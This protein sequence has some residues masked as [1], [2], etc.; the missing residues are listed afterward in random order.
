MLRRGE[1]R[2]GERGLTYI[3]QGGAILGSDVGCLRDDA[4]LN[5]GC[6]DFDAE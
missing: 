5:K 3:V 4:E 6:E 1:E 2:R